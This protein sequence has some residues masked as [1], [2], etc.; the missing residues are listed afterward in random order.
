MHQVPASC[1]LFPAPGGDSLR[2]LGSR[3][4]LGSIPDFL[5]KMA[6][7]VVAEPHGTCIPFG[8][9]ESRMTLEAFRLKSR[10]EG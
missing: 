6:A 4:D 5:E 10:I 8:R 9:A 3:R 2:C 1:I 7:P